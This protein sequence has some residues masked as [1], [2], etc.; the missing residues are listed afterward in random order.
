MKVPSKSLK[1]I[2]IQPLSQRGSW[3]W[4]LL[5]IVCLAVIDTALGSNVTCYMRR[6]P[7]VMKVHKW[8]FF[9]MFPQED[10]L[11]GYQT[12]IIPCTKW[13]LALLLMK[14]IKERVRNLPI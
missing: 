7:H 2:S 4:I 13:T 6:L 14:L 3:S 5:E 8:L 10:K 9:P 12:G 11:F 1:A